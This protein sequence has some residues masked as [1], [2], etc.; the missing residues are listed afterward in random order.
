MKIKKILLFGFFLFSNLNIYSSKFSKKALLDAFALQ[1]PIIALIG[2]GCQ[3]GLSSKEEQPLNS[4]KEDEIK[5]AV[6]KLGLDPNKYIYIKSDKWASTSFLNRIYVPHKQNYEAPENLFAIAH[7]IG[8]ITHK[9]SY[10]SLLLPAFLRASV[11][12]LPI[13]KVPFKNKIKLW[14][15]LFILERLG[16]AP[17]SRY[18]EKRADIFA[19]N[20]VNDPSII[21]AGYREL[22]G[23]KK[24]LPLSE[25]YMD[26][27]YLKVKAKEDSFFNNNSF[28]TQSHPCSERRALYLE[29]YAQKIMRKQNNSL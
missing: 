24:S 23:Y 11:L 28:F 19:A 18:Q 6:G 16:W 21:R 12:L 8:H 7:E 14:G 22:L 15:S 27:E 26:M 4:I 9:D 20:L 10:V 17:Y 2:L 13:P 5:K 3:I 25:S 1:E 29:E